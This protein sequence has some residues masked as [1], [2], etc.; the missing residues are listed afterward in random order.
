MYR[1]AVDLMVYVF[2]TPHKQVTKRLMDFESMKF[3]PTQSKFLMVV[4]VG[5]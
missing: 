4:L 5:H 2:S 1:F 3:I